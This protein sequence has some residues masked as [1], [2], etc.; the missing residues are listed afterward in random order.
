MDYMSSLAQ[1]DKVPVDMQL[2]GLA[3]LRSQRINDN[4][5]LQKMFQANEQERVMNPMRV[6]EQRL[7]NKGMDVDIL[8]K[9]TTLADLTRKNRMA[10][11]TYDAE[12]KAKLSKL[13]A[14]ASDD[15][16]K[17]AENEI[18]LGLQRMPNNPV[19]RQQLLFMHDF[20]KKEIE[21][22]KAHAR[23]LTEID[24]AGQW[25]VN[26]AQVTGNK[27]APDFETNLFKLKKAHEQHAA[28]IQEA[29]RQELAGNTQLA[30]SY[31]LRAAVIRPQAEAEL[32]ALR[33][34]QQGAVDIDTMTQG[35]IPTVKAPSIA[36]PQ[37]Q[38]TPNPKTPSQAPK[39]QS[40]SQLNVVPEGTKSKSKSGKPIV[41]RNG[42][43]EYE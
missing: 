14:D 34:G 29:Q 39:P 36:P 26:R 17:Q 19:A 31:R 38:P 18:I 21:A 20:T 23:K 40:Q 13:Y 35:Q 7:R 8:T 11:S 42:R 1:L 32:D 43:W 24:A 12:L 15:D 4:L 37:V 16:L 30:E 6:E 41:F 9:E 27:V 10:E 33:R 3:G 2:E 5:N 28:L 22:R 25:G